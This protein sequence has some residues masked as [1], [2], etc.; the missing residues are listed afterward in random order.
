MDL[1]FE[2]DEIEGS[3]E[4]GTFMCCCFSYGEES[5]SEGGAISPLGP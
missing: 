2:S 3:K 5:E 4:R 1:S